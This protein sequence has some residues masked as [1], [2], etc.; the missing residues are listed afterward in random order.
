MIVMLS[1][2][3]YH[4]YSFKKVKNTPEGVLLNGLKITKKCSSTKGETMQ[5]KDLV[6]VRVMPRT[7]GQSFMRKYWT[8]LKRKE[9][10][11][12]KNT[13]KWPRTEGD[14]IRKKSQRSDH[15]SNIKSIYNLYKILCKTS[16][17]SQ[18]IEE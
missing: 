4:F 16:N 2:I 9:K 14:I 3:W 5:K 7:S 15:Q 13:S 11:E 10:H 18:E 1:A 12:F 8:V 17:G 6:T